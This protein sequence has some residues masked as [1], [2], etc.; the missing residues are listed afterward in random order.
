MLYV[1][2][3]VKL[4]TIRK[5]YTLTQKFLFSL[6]VIHRQYTQTIHNVPIKRLSKLYYLPAALSLS[7]HTPL[8]RGIYYYRLLSIAHFNAVTKHFRKLQNPA[9]SKLSLTCLLFRDKDIQPNIRKRFRNLETVI[10]ELTAA[11]ITRK[12]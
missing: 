9:K 4:S 8:N 5:I 12:T 6:K 1:R 2:I 3:Y 11:V 7:I 10:P